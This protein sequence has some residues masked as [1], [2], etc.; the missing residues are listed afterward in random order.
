MDAI[1]DDMKI[2]RLTAYQPSMSMSC[3]LTSSK[4]QWK[5]QVLR[6]MVLLSKVRIETK[7]FCIIPL[8]KKEQTILPQQ[9]LNANP[10]SLKRLSNIIYEWFAPRNNDAIINTIND[11][12]SGNTENVVQGNRDETLEQRTDISKYD[13]IAWDYI[14]RKEN[15]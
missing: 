10:D 8:D 4:E 2:L 13:L 14:S 12:L 1:Y 15:E 7:G 6:K 11:L 5:S 3:I 9:I